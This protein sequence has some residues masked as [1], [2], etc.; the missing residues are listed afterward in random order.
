MNHQ[1][2]GPV[3]ASGQIQWK[4]VD[5]GASDMPPQGRRSAKDGFVQ[6]P[7]IIGGVV[8]VTNLDAVK[9]GELEAHR[10]GAG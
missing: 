8:P 10:P 4:T 5:F 3:A 7:A 1:S 2:I 9:P 6:F